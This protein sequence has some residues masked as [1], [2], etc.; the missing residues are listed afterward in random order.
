MINCPCPLPGGRRHGILKLED[1]VNPVLYPH[2]LWSIMCLWF[3]P[4]LYGIQPFIPFRQSCQEF[5]SSP[6]FC[7]SGLN[8]APCFCLSPYSIPS[9]DLSLF[10]SWNT[11]G[12]GRTSKYPFQV[13][14]DPA[15]HPASATM[16]NLAKRP[17][18]PLQLPSFQGNPK[19]PLVGKCFLF[20]L[21]RRMGY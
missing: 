13:L 1:T 3:P 17:P 10:P 12:M 4:C 11:P 16:P 9:N 21:Q 8:L 20:K 18:A 15:R 2:H 14:I 19:V 7:L 6:V 5:A